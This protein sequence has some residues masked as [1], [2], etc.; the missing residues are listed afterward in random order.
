MKKIASSKFENR[1]FIAF[2][3]NIGNRINFLRA[4]A[5]A[6]QKD[7]NMEIK[8]LSP[9]YETKPYGNKKQS[10]FLNAVIEIKTTYSLMKC[11][12]QLKTIE[13]QI[14][15][16]KT[17]KWGPREID[18]DLLFYNNKIFS[19]KK[20]TVPHKD[21]QN[22]D[23][24]LIPLSDIAGEYIHPVLKLKISDICNSDMNKN[25]VRKTRY[26]LFPSKGR[27]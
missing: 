20:V 11:F 3:S 6:I 7:S 13:K 10:N 27:N 18:L 24:V 2:G 4:A 15:R 5:K 9:V 25:I 1:A 14:G 21:I 19:N 22:R 16:Q 23:F 17:V 26:K 12:S 8:R